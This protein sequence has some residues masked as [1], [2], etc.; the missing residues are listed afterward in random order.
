MDIMYNVYMSCTRE[1]WKDLDIGNGDFLEGF[2]VLIVVVQK[3][4]MLFVVC[5]HVEIN[6]GSL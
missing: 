6:V 2:K 3:L 4:Y 1:Y 5:V